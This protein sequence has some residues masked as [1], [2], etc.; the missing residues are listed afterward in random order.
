MGKKSRE[1]KERQLR[2]AETNFPKIPKER[3]L[4]ALYLKI[5]RWGSFLILLTPLIVG[6]N[7][8]FPSFAPKTLYFWALT[9]IIFIFYLLLIAKSAKYRPKLNI[10]FLG[11]VLFVIVLV[12]ASFIG[13]N[14]SKSFWGTFE[15]MGGLLT[16]FHL[17]AFFTVVVS[18]FKR[19]E[20]WFSLFRFSVVAAG[21]VSIINLLIRAGID[22]FKYPDP[23][24]APVGNS[25]FLGAYLLFNGFFAL[26]LFFKTKSTDWKIFYTFAFL[27][28]FFAL[29]F[30]GARAAALC[31][32]GGLFLLFIL[33]LAFAASKPFL[34]KIGIALLAVSI[35]GGIFSLYSLFQSDSFLHNK[36][37]EISTK[38]RFVVWEIGWKGWQERPW[39]GWGPGNFD[40]VLAKYF[41]PCLPLPECGG[42]VWFDRV[43]NIILDTGVGSGILGV[44]AYLGIFGISFFLLLK[45]FLRERE[46]LIPGI[47][48]VILIA[49]FVQNLTVFDMVSGYIM[50]FLVF[51]FIQVTTRK[52]KTAEAGEQQ[53][54]NRGFFSRCRQAGIVL[55]I[56]FLLFSFLKFVV[57][58]AKAGILFIK[59]ASGGNLDSIREIDYSQEGMDASSLGKYQTRII[60]GSLINKAE[61]E[62]TK[63]NQEI[64]QKG[65]QIASDRLEKSIKEHPFHF[66]SFVTLGDIYNH[67]PGPDPAKLLRAEEVLNQALKLSPA[68][69]IGYYKLAETKFSQNKYKE[70]VGLLQKAV[71]LNPEY[72]RSHYLLSEAAAKIGDSEMAE[73]EKQAA[74]KAEEEL[75]KLDH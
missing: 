27:I 50:L 67:Y 57:Q 70:A 66:R 15:R 32:L 74:E 35:I 38:S 33:Y 36:F 61:Q 41:N 4:V 24:G 11:I 26:Y 10:L 19:E 49:Y 1:K 73:K 20:D 2:Q 56:V 45:K 5:I 3:G 21:I 22:P 72:P 60:F 18:V 69:Q 8:V 58:P 43:H 13:I 7:F 65:F 39:L 37:I 59:G 29:I 28:I 31:F 64:I 52:E 9:E 14:S 40:V 47:F 71:E 16:W 44:L 6:K 25:S 17:L 54:C 55:L 23:T 75:W 42:E 53:F 48:T 34:K 63:A 12:L 62:N 68:N 30:S 46:F 51:G